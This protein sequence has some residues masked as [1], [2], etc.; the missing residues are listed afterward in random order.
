MGHKT[1]EILESGELTCLGCNKTKQL[2]EFHRCLSSSTGVQNQCKECRKGVHQL[3]CGKKKYGVSLATYYDMLANQSGKCGVCGTRKPDKSGKLSMFNIDHDHRTGK[4][5]G[6]LCS[7]CN[8]GIGQ[9]GDTVEAVRKALDY[10]EKH[11]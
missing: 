5:R 3:S 10:L 11:T 8:L 6:L 2:T 4:V 9:L 1:K 7:D